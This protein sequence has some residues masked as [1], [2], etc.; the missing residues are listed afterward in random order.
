METGVSLW[1]LS[2]PVVRP[3][4]QRP[5][6]VGLVPALPWGVEAPVCGHLESPGAFLGT[7]H[8]SWSS[9]L[10]AP[11]GAAGPSA[12]EDRGWEAR[13]R[14]HLLWSR[15]PVLCQDVCARVLPAAIAS[16]PGT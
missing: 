10:R 6:C 5:G 15:E 14:S 11:D 3:V 2:D 12:D 9:P 1:R 16:L 13:L 7:L 8:T 4:A